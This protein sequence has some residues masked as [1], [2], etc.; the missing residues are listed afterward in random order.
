MCAFYSFGRLLV[1]NFSQL[2]LVLIL[3]RLLK[4]EGNGQF[5]VALL[6]P[7]L[8]TTIFN[9]GIPSANIYFL[10]RDSVSFSEAL[11]SNV[12][13]WSIFSA[14]GMIVSAIVICFF[15]EKL[16]P[17]VPRHL[18]WGSIA[19][20]P[21]SLLFIILT[22]I[23]QAKQRFREYNL[24]LIVPPISNLLLSFVYIK[25]RMNNQVRAIYRAV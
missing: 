6:L 9:V 23:I 13:L 2:V 8:L 20:F 15:S 3:A 19:I 17:G 25:K 16:F 14:L 24:A 12:L 1:V 4:P 5:F 11:K 21:V 10:A 18:L 22:S 7:M